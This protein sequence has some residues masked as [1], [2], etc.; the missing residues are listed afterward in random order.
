MKNLWIDCMSDGQVRWLKCGSAVLALILFSSFSASAQTMSLQDCI[1]YALQHNNTIKQHSISVQNQEVALNS[2]KMSRLPDV[3]A[4]IGQGWSFGRSTNMSTNSYSSGNSTSTNLSVSASVDL[5]T[6][7]RTENQIKSDKFSLLAATA[8]LEKARKDVGIQVAGYYLNALYC[9]G[10]ADV[11]RRQVELDSVAVENARSLFELGKKPESEVASAEAQLAVSRHNLT[12]AIGNETLARL[13]LMQSLNL[14]GDVSSFFIMDIDTT[15]LSA[16]VTSSGHIFANAVERYPSILA[17]KYELESSRYDLKTSRSGYMPRLSLSAGIGTGYQYMYDWYVRREEW[18]AAGTTVVR[19]WMEKAPQSSFGTQ[20]SDN[21]SKSI[22]LNLTIPIFDRFTTRN[23]MR[24][25]RLN[26]E[27][28]TTALAEAQQSLN[29]EIQQAYWNAIKARDNYVSSQKANASTSLAYQYESDR[30][31][32]G[33]GTAYE[34]QLASSKMQKAQQDEI[35]AKYELLM[36]LKI[37]EFYT[38]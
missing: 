2:T 36:R 4:N 20:L 38:E 6:G 33:R 15:Q 1:D 8:N 31:A 28:R 32:A 37:L 27:S 26:I 11:Q 23:S 22:S 24:R 25:A 5:F 30:Y 18:D 14:E 34:L 29:K 12:E 3:S 16:D 21:L 10:L 7:F 13:D 17:A 35:Q 19:S 9:R